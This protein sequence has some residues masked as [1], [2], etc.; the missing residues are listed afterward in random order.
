MNDTE[1]ERGKE[2]SIMYTQTQNDWCTSIE[3]SITIIR[4]MPFMRPNIIDSIY[5][6]FTQGMSFCNVSH[7]W[8]RFVYW[9]V[10]KPHITCYYNLYMNIWYEQL[11]SWWVQ[12]TFK[13]ILI[14]FHNTPLRKTA[15]IQFS[16]THSL[17][18]N[19]ILN[20]WNGKKK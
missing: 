8:I 11:M 5:A 14:N 18:F 6:H 17:E 13:L 3:I 19:W 16:G 7:V 2:K 15:P 9:P 4:L 20:K 1:R 10:F 12:N